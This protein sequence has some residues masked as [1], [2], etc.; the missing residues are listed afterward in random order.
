MAVAGNLAL[1]L[2]TLFND[3]CLFHFPPLALFMCFK[4][5]CL[6]TAH[7]KGHDPPVSTKYSDRQ[8]ARR[9]TSLM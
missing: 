3:S 7:H 6:V 4:E 8:Q 1:E 9:I 2:T 5:V